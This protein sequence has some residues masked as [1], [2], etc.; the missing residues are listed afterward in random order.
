MG[1]QILGMAMQN[2]VWLAIW[3]LKHPGLY[4]AL[5]LIL[6]SRVG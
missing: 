4:C 5:L 3:P 1:H 6:F 2:A